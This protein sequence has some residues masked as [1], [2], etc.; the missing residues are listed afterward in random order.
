MGIKRGLSQLTNE[1]WVGIR[2]DEHGVEDQAD[3]LDRENGIWKDLEARKK[4][5]NLRNSI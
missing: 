3:V 2:R 4:V 1:G 5:T